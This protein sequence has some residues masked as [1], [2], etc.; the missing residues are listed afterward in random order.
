MG[1]R[2]RDP[3]SL[4]EAS[5]DDVTP[6]RPSPALA[7][8]LLASLVLSGCASWASRA[9]GP[10]SALDRG[11]Y[12]KAIEQFDEL[13]K[14]RDRDELLYLMDLGMAA[15][16]ASRYE[17]AIRALRRADELA[18]VKDYTSITEE[19]AAILL[20]DEVKPYKGEDFEKVLINAY[21]AVDY[22]LLGKLEE[23]LIECRRVNHKLD[24]YIREGQ[25]PYKRNHFAKYLAGALFEAGREWNDAF[26]DY[27][28]LLS[29]GGD[30]ALLAG[31]LLRLAHVL[32]AEQEMASYRGRF[33]NASWKI[34]RDEG[35]IILIVE[36][37]R[38]PRK[39]PSEQFHLVP[40]FDKRPYT[41]DSVVLRAGEGRETRSRTLF[42]IEET[43]IRELDAKMAAILAKKVGGVAVKQLVADRVAKETES[44][45]LGFLTA[46]FLHASDRADLRSWSTLP[47]KLQIARLVVPSGRLDVELDMVRISGEIQRNVRRW[48]GLEVR[49][50]AKV[51][52]SHRAIE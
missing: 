3:Q 5:R 37:G 20:H 28:Q 35:E 36:V 44:K 10:Q 38:S 23:A 9:R 45:F 50:G 42:D 40:R 17:D 19:S 39:V 33:K 8:A 31:P 25:L 15:H 29:W 1:G 2:E 49:P 48:A 24:R 32:Q 26:V 12:D 22:A 27:R 11:E 6:A 52:L 30:E 47:A 43:A 18:D 21:L 51:F 14:R 34:G 13:A 16:A 41:A 7:F 46:L 4:Q